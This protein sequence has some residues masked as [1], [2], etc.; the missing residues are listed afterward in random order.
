MQQLR[1]LT[2]NGYL[3]VGIVLTF[4]LLYL[5]VAF[6]IVTGTKTRINSDRATPE[7]APDQ[8][9][10]P[11]HISTVS[12]PVMIAPEEDPSDI[13]AQIALNLKKQL[14]G[15]DLPGMST[16]AL[17]NKLWQSDRFKGDKE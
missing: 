9:S 6:L 12:P 8:S 16:T 11:D 2:A 1:S 4:L 14:S 13:R 5:T 3:Y 10:L 17:L 15:R 7:N